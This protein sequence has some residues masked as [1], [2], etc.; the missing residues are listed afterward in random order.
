MNHSIV[1]FILTSVLCVIN[2]ATD[3]SYFPQTKF[4]GNDMA[5]LVVSN[6][7]ACLGSCLSTY[8]CK[9]WTFVSNP[10]NKVSV[11][12][13]DFLN[14]KVYQKLELISLLKYKIK[15]VPPF[16]LPY[17][18]FSSFFFSSLSFTTQGI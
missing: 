4:P 16:L 8:Q 11:N 1:F 2:A 9:G 3:A 10:S 13:G 12:F 17:I 7:M 6:A 18:C 5:S 15:I 14:C